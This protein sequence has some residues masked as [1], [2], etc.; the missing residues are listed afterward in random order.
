[1]I[2]LAYL[3][4]AG[5][6]LYQ[7]FHR[8]RAFL[9]R[10][11]TAGDRQLASGVALFLLVP[12]GVLLHE[13]GHMA[14]TWS[15]GG[16]VQGLSYFF[17]WGYVTIDLPSGDPAA[18]WY[19][20]VAGN[21]VSYLL[22]ILCVALAVL[23]RTLIPTLRLVLLDLGI[24]QLV[25]TLIGYPVLSLT[26]DFGGDWDNIYSFESP[27]ASWATL[28]VHAVSLVGFILFLRR[29]REANYLLNGPAAY[30]SP[31]ET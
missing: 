18:S 5:F 27:L 23:W 14:A 12:V 2:A 7:L 21:I 6:T 4:G 28:A 22:G 19:V 15:I 1:M 26:T 17:Y 16:Q 13:F 30:S 20:A 3:A 10:S 8:W 25:L 9:D 24:Y 31:S 11:F 29:S